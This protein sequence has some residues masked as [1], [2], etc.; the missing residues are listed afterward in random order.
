MGAAFYDPRVGDWTFDTCSLR[1]LEAGGFLPT[2]V[3]HFRGRAHLVADV[4]RELP[5]LSLVTRLP[6]Y[7]EHKVMLPEHQILYRALRAK[8]ASAPG[9]DEGEAACIT[10][11]YSNQ[12]ALISDD[13]VAVRTASAPPASLPVMRTAALLI[14]MVR[15][16]SLTADDAWAGYHAMRAAGRT[17]LGPPLWADRASFDVLCAV[18]GFDPRP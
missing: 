16:G 15:A 4:V 11:A 12:W 3:L 10:L 14:A 1:N 5:G 7:A 18:A 6:W 9:A 2:V 13:G 17:K 8:W